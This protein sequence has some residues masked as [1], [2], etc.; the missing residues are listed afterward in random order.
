MK[1]VRVLA[2]VSYQ[3]KNIFGI[4]NIFLQQTGNHEDLKLVA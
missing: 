2:K 3:L 1:A 4:N